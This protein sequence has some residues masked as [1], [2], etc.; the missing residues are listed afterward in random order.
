MLLSSQ[1]RGPCHLASADLFPLI[2]SSMSAL[3]DL[4]FTG[5][6]PW[7][8]A[9]GIWLLQTVLYLCY[10]SMRG[11]YERETDDIS[12]TIVCRP[13]TYTVL[14]L[15]V[16]KTIKFAAGSYRHIW[17]FNLAS[18]KHI[19]P[20]NNTSTGEAINIQIRVSWHRCLRPTDQ[21]SPRR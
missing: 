10:Y 19:Q 18:S 1:R 17:L 7:S 12:I 3:Q 21:P 11:V 9:S 14:K 16:H 2:S 15:L 20:S 4:R 13:S 8:S 6:K 5:G